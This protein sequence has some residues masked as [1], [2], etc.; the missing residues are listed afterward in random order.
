MD[1]SANL[2]AGPSRI[3]QRRALAKDTKHAHYQ[4][5]R[6]E[7]FSAASKL[8][9]SR[10]YRGTS[11]ADIAKEVGADRASLYYYFGSKE[12][13]FDDL[14]TNVVRGNLAIAENIRDSEDPAPAKLRHLI[15]GLMTSYAEHYPILYVYL[16]ENMAHVAP[17]R[18]AWATEMRAVNRRYENAV[19]QII[20]VGIDEGTL[21][22]VSEPWV[23]AYGVMGVV[24]WTNRWFNP[25]TSEIDAPSIGEAYADMILGGLVLSK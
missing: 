15:V 7:I 9:K 21:R 16:Q 25:Q 8:F 5:R 24:S 19:K 22:N 12:E 17:K 6:A 1:D 20:Q 2:V 11:L 18:Q 13:L 14:V 23:L 4:D 10:G 3:G